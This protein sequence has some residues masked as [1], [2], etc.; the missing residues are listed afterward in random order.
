M[1][2][3]KAEDDWLLLPMLLYV[4]E[5]GKVE[6]FNHKLSIYSYTK[7]IHCGVGRRVESETRNT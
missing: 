6:T 4:T 3:K 7:S 2:V 5:K 1:N